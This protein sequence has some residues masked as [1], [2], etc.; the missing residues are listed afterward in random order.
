MPSWLISPS[1]VLLCRF[2]CANKNDPLVDQVDLQEANPTYAH[3]CYMDGRQSTVSLRDLA[4]CPSIPL[5]MAH[6]QTPPMQP[7]GASQNDAISERNRI[8]T[9]PTEGVEP[10][11]NQA[12]RCSTR[13]IKPPLRYGYPNKDETVISSLEGKNDV[14]YELYI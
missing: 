4:P 10:C 7:E 14:N 5:D 3:V 2:V 6:T 12:L 13:E 9:S 11:Q 1:P 8:I